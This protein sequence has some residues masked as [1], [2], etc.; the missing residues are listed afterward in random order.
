MLEMGG[1]KCLPEIRR[2]N[3]NA[4]VVMASGYSESGQASV[5]IKGGARR[6]I[7]KP[8]ETTLDYYS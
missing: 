3:P 4:K 7:Q 5:V 8:Y 6:F 2:I 1:E